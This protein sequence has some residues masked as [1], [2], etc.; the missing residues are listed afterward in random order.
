[1]NSMVEVKTLSVL[2]IRSPRIETTLIRT[3]PKFLSVVQLLCASMSGYFGQ[4]FF[5][6]MKPGFVSVDMWTRKIFEFGGVRTLPLSL[7]PSSI[8]RKL[9]YGVGYHESV[10]LSHFFHGYRQCGTLPTNCGA[11]YCLF[12]TTRAILQ[13]PARQCD[14]IYSDRDNHFFTRIH[15]RQTDFLSKLAA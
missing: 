14:R 4:C 3:P 8:H 7:K 2:H 13:V 5:F 15:R 10:S 12:R 9:E 1:M 6:W 11:F